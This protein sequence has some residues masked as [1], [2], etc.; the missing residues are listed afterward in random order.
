MLKEVKMTIKMREKHGKG[1]E[2]LKVGKIRNEKVEWSEI[3]LGFGSYTQ[4]L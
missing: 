2:W 3:G 1:R 4:Y